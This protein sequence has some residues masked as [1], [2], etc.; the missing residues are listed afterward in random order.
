MT[1]RY[2]IAAGSILAAVIFFST[3][4]QATLF[5][6]SEGAATSTPAAISATA[7]PGDY[8]ARLRIPALGI[9]AK[10]QQAGLTASNAMGTPTNFI[11]VAWYKYGPVPGQ[12]GSA[13]IDGHVD[14]GLSL[15]GVF[16]HLGDIA[17]GDDVYVDT[18]EGRPLH[19][20]V[21]DIETYPYQDTPNDLIFSR[22]DQPRLNL[23]TCEGTWVKGDKTYSERLV[24]YAVLQP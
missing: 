15:A 13:V 3:L 6:P 4:A 8:P 10:V 14:N 2:A 22:A 21:A 9:D 24:V 23:I 7:A 17:I 11:D 20:V 19:F 18:K 16:K 5:A 1:L 12:L